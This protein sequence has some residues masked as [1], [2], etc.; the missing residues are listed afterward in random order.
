MRRKTF[1]KFT[2]FTVMFLTLCFALGALNAQNMN[3]PIKSNL[4][5]NSGSLKTTHLSVEPHTFYSIEEKSKCP[6]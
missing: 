1:R 2:L 4:F 5:K 6:E 3:K